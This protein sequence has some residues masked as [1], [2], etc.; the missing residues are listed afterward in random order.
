[1]PSFLTHLAAVERLTTAGAIGTPD[2]GRIVKEDIEYARLGALLP[3]LPYFEGPR[4]ALEFLFPHSHSPHFANA[5]HERAPVAMGIKMAELVSMGA[6]VGKGPG[7]AFLVGYFSHLCLDRILHPL[8]FSMAEKHRRPREDSWTAHRR[9]EWIQGL[10]LYRETYGCEPSRDGSLRSRLQIGKHPGFPRGIG[11]GLFEIVRVASLASL[12][13]APSKAQADSWVR[14]LYA[15]TLVLS[16]PVGRA[17]VYTSRSLLQ[18]R[19]LF[20]T[21]LYQDGLSRALALTSEIAEIICQLVQRG[22]FRKRAVTKVFEKLPEG[23][24]ALHAA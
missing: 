2:L 4:G 9:I 24:V 15:H 1:M 19:T 5:F 8:V 16:S 11:G 13:E 12:Y 20:A 18:V 22:T 14:G 7:I 6:L 10:E 17:H 21:S 3:D 23:S